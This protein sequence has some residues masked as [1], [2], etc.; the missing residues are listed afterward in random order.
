MHLQ[1][2]YF[3]SIFTITS[4]NVNI[5]NLTNRNKIQ[6]T[7]TLHI[8]ITNLQYFTTRNKNSTLM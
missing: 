3:E 1:K 4:Q 7:L 5:F 8:Y 6:I 2:H